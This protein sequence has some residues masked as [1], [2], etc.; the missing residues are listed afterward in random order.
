MAK[1]KIRKKKILTE[2]SLNCGCGEKAPVFE[3][4]KGYMAHCLGCGAVTFFDNPLLLQRLRFGSKLCPHELE[5]KPCRGGHTTWCP[6]CRVRHFSYDNH[7]TKSEID[8]GLVRFRGTA[9][10]IGTR[11]TNGTGN[12]RKFTYERK[13]REF[14]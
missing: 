4:E 12:Y 2:Y 1:S 3:L 8:R 6:I 11:E 13:Y 9:R 14:Q 5:A 10:T 7:S